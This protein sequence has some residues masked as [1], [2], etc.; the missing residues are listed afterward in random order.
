MDFFTAHMWEIF[1]GLVAA[2]ALA[3]CKYLHS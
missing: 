3:L 1:F 2:G